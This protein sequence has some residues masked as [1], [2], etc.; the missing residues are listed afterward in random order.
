MQAICSSETSGGFQQT[1]R[2]HIP[3]DTIHEADHLLELFL[4]PEEGGNIF[5]R[6][7]K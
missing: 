7:A 4:D 1:T 5:I 6:V 2:H 3:D